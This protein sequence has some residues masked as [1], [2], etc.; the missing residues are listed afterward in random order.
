M[1]EL[2]FLRYR[3][4]DVEEI[5]RHIC[6]LSVEDFVV[7]NPKDIPNAID[8]LE[9]VEVAGRSFLRKEFTKRE[10]WKCVALCK[11]HAMECRMESND[12]R[13]YIPLSFGISPEELPERIASH[14]GIYTQYVPRCKDVYTLMVEE[15]IA[16]RQNC[17]GDSRLKR[18]KKS[19]LTRLSILDVLCGNYRHGGNILVHS[20]GWV[21][22]ID[23]DFAFSGSADGDEYQMWGRFDGP[24][25]GRTMRMRWSFRMQDILDHE[26]VARNLDYER[27]VGRIGCHFPQGIMRLMD[28]MTSMDDASIEEEFGVALHAIPAMRRRMKSL[29]TYGLEGTLDRYVRIRDRRFQHLVC[30][31]RWL[32]P[33]TEDLRFRISHIFVNLPGFFFENCRSL[34]SH[35]SLFSSS[36]H[37]N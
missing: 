37:C 20:S 16:R 23:H 3:A 2:N 1:E 5:K 6:G 30:Q 22:G 4:D 11:I 13:G 32:P 17:Q 28:L 33:T 26:N 27:H 31:G 7:T 14:A 29:R 15:S 25:L 21:V 9:L 35:P 19:S 34:A 12:A 24:L 10:A 18:L 36:L 8:H